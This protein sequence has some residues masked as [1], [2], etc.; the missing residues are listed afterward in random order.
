METNQTGGAPE[1]DK[2]EV[3]TP[4]EEK[5]APPAQEAAEAPATEDKAE[6]PE[7]PRKKEKAELLAL[8]AENDRLRKEQAEQKDMYQRVLAEYANYKRRT[9]Q[10]K[11]RL[12]EYT[13]AELLKALLVSLDNME[14]AIE[15]PAGD[16]YKTGVDMVLR[17]FRDT[18]YGMG[19]QEIEAEGA[20]FNPEM[21]NAVMREDAD[22]VE[23]ETITA[24]FQKGYRYG[25][26][27][28]RPAMVKVAN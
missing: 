10:E 20:V 27:V 9:E 4:E 1:K 12:G 23:P 13:R 25:D 15:A 3:C 18:L 21:H 14:R 16:E 7:K 11:E 2:E 19:L 6:K 5:A 24:V 26:R 28:L 22:G 17:Q 8:R